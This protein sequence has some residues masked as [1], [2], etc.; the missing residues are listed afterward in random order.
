MWY[1]IIV[2]AVIFGAIGLIMLLRKIQFDNV[3]NNLL[4]IQ[5]QYDG[6]VIRRGFAALPVF[7]GKFHNGVLVINFSTLRGDKGGREGYATFSW[8]IQLPFPITVFSKAWLE[9]HP[10]DD[11]PDTRNIFIEK[12]RISSPNE[13]VLALA[14]K[15][16]GLFAPL[17]TL[18]HFVYFFASNR[19]VMFEVSIES[20]D[21]GSKPDFLN[22]TLAIIGDFAN[23]LKKQKRNV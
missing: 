20:L 17:Q 14:E 1:A 4:E 15:Q 12:L 21:L 22:A 13:N 3:H 9:M 8:D 23:A 19:G 6:E 7:H 5:E 2:F 10:T 18:D 16:P 11:N